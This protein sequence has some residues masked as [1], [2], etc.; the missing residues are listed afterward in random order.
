MSK[1][2]DIAVEDR[3][4][5]AVLRRLLAEAPGR[6]RVGLVHPMRRSWDAS[7]SSGGYGYIRKALPGF[8]AIAGFQPVVVLVDAD[9]RVCPPETISEWLGGK[10]HHPSLIVRVAVREVEAWLLA[11]ADGMSEFLSVRRDCLP[12]ETQ[13]LKDPKRYLVRLAARSRRRDIREELAPAVGTRAKTGP[14]FTAAV[15]GFARDLWNPEAAAKNNDSL[16]RARKALDS[17]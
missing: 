4:S 9:N 13:R 1:T 15:S 12:L 2:V 3:L 5:E 17:L 10:R 6:L 8:N 14:F 16:R 11:D 7:G